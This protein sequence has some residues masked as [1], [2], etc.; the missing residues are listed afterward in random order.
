[1]DTLRAAFWVPPVIQRNKLAT[2]TL[3][4]M[5]ILMLMRVI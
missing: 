5:T 4:V 3:V 1:M 2:L